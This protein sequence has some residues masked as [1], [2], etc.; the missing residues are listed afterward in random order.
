LSGVLRKYAY[1]RY[2]EGRAAHWL[3]LL[4]ADRVDAIEG[5][6]ASFVTLRPDN[7]LTETGI[8]SE[9]THHGWKA[10]TGTTR[11]DNSHTWIDP[12]LVAGPWV[13]VAMLMGKA[14]RALAK[15]RSR[16]LP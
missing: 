3:L 5:H 13:V 10:R 1:R 4:G 11:V 2:S 6:L 9:F 15:R 12:I 16:P 14:G 7:P 8:R